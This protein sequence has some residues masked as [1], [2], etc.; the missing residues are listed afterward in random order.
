VWPGGEIITKG[1]LRLTFKLSS[2]VNWQERL[3]HI[4]VT[5]AYATRNLILLAWTFRR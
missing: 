5:P 3:G 2:K 4:H 1:E